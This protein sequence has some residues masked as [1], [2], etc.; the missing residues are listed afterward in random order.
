MGPRGALQTRNAREAG[1]PAYYLPL[2]IHWHSTIESA[3][4]VTEASQ[5]ALLIYTW[6]PT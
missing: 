6:S 1:L 3:K 5:R 4:V 2:M